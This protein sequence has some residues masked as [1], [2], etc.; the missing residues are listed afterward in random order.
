MKCS[1][2]CLK[3]TQRIAFL[4]DCQIT[5]LT[6]LKNYEIFL[7]KINTFNN[8]TRFFLA[9]LISSAYSQQPRSNST[10][11][12]NCLHQKATDNT[13]CI[14]MDINSPM[15][16]FLKLPDLNNPDAAEI[17]K[18]RFIGSDFESFPSQLFRN[19]K[20]LEILDAS[21]VHLSRLERNDIGKTNLKTFNV[22]FNK[23]H[24]LKEGMTDNLENLVN[25][26]LSHNQ[27]ER[28]FPDAFKFN[29]D[30]RFLNLSHNQISTLD[31]RFFE[32]V[33]S[34]EVLKLNDNNITDITGNFD[35]FISNFNELDLSNNFLISI[36]P[37]MVKMPQYLDVSFNKIEKL[38]LHEAKTL[39]LKIVSNSL[40]ELS[41]GRRLRK[42]DASENHKFAFQIK[43]EIN[44]NNLTHLYL[45][46]IKNKI[47]GEKLFIDFT[48]FDRLEVLDLSGNN[49][50]HFD[51]KD[52]TEKRHM[53]LRELNL[54]DA[55]LRTLDNYKD[56]DRIL[57]NLKVIDIFDNMFVCAEVDPMI[58]KFLELN[59]TLP[60]YQNNSEYRSRSCYSGRNERFYP[61][62]TES[63]SAMVAFW[64]CF[65]I[66]SFA[67]IVIAL[68][69]INKRIAIFQKLYDTI[70]LN[71]SYKSRGGSKL[72]DEEKVHEVENY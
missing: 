50:I 40:Q 33:K 11:K 41:I 14:F 18:L 39:E 70:K 61:A 52:L 67:S 58:N 23:I 21:Y 62:K 47:D 6:V 36:D 42:L 46:Y 1:K 25:F 31:S 29:S 26:D 51:L 59:L 45:S 55:H 57:P 12:L 9:L 19:F 16:L 37:G 49:I 17:K 15:D 4:E 66:I 32:T 68:F 48:R 69:F 43:C 5:N 2:T 22:S 27:I 56:I 10:V 30:L 72:L 35:L 3:A 60:N 54:R 63:S 34:C 38:D 64:V 65:I 8:S 44:R 71:P 53:T 13:S 20:N 24:R 28:I 7:S